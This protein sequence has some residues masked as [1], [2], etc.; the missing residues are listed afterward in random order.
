MSGRPVLS[1]T[2]LPSGSTSDRSAALTYVGVGSEGA[3]QESAEGQGGRGK[4]E[5]RTSL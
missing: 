2:K 4:D 1:W 3:G 5:G